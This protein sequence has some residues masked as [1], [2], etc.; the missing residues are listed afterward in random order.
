MRH[1]HPPP[2]LVL[3][4]SIPDQVRDPLPRYAA[5]GRKNPT[6]CPCS[7]VK[8][9]VIEATYTIDETCA[10]GSTAQTRVTVLGGHGEEAESGVRTLDSDYLTVTVSGQTCTSESVFL[11]ASGPA[12]FS[13]APSLKTARSVGTVTT[14]DGQAI[15]VSMTWR[16][17]GGKET[18][19][20]TTTFPGFTGR[21]TGQRRD[22]VAS[23]TVVVNGVTIVDGT[24]TSAR[25]ET[26]EDRNITQS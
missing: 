2:T 25:I 26:L 19:K 24:T 17:I 5:N 16:G 21:F 9:R 12:D 22:A 11:R 13:F 20:N 14:S 3:P 8:A 1:K 4:L 15:T 23:G 6:P 10:D 7:G 18:T